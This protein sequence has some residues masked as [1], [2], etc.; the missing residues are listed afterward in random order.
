[1]S[2]EKI[3]KTF[4]KAFPLVVAMVVGL[5]FFYIS[6]KVNQSVSDLLVNI[7]AAFIA[8][9]LLYILYEN[10]KKFA[11]RKLTRELF[12]FTKS[13]V[14]YEMLS[15][16]RQLR[17]MIYNEE[18]PGMSYDGVKEVLCLK[19]NQLKK[20]LR[21][22]EYLGF[23]ILKKWEVSTVNLEEFLRNPLILSKTEDE[24]IISIIRILKSI[25]SLQ[26]IQ[27]VEGL[28]KDNGKTAENYK[29]E[30]G[31][32][33]NPANNLYSE[34]KLLLKHVSNNKFIVSDFGDIKTSDLKNCLRYYK[35]N[36]VFLGLYIETVLSL[37]ENINQ[38]VEETG[39]RLLLG[40]KVCF[41]IPKSK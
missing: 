32:S 33:L 39:G 16:I 1:M 34:R 4:L 35:I 29:V 28:Y 41:K 27:D 19:E 6:L 40:T 12:D 14:D 11:H 3:N 7:S 13:E 17:K 30:D 24:Y 5:A 25:R 18:E 10:V 21:N 26:E 20:I 22:N 8:I 23:K 9:P 36:K 15:V 31:T 38:W 37:I 2:K